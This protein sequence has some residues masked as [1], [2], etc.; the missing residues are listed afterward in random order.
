MASSLVLPF[1][2]ETTEFGFC[3]QCLWMLSNQNLTLS[4]NQYNYNGRILLVSTCLGTT[5]L[6]RNRQAVSVTVTRAPEWILRAEFEF[7]SKC[8]LLHQ[9]PRENHK[10]LVYAPPQHHK[11]IPK[12]YVSEIMAWTG[13]SEK[14]PPSRQVQIRTLQGVSVYPHLPTCKQVVDA[15]TLRMYT[16]GTNWMMARYIST[17]PRGH[18]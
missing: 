8:S 17:H 15:A 1:S 14:Y 12:W 4:Y 7:R 6:R 11:M 3:F 16:G 5:A 2:Q 9:H 10:S 13:W 18:R